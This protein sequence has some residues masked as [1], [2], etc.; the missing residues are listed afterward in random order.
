MSETAFKT[1][2][3]HFWSVL[4]NVVKINTGYCREKLH[5]P[6]FMMDARKYL[7]IVTE[8]FSVIIVQSSCETTVYSC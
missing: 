6:A 7:D 3:E 2:L 4:L 1:C 8:S 5:R